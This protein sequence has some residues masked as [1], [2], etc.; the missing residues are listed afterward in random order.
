MISTS[1]N[2]P[3]TSNWN[4]SKDKSACSDSIDS[5]SSKHSLEVTVHCVPASETPGL[6]L[7][8]LDQHIHD[9]VKQDSLTHRTPTKL[10]GQSGCSPGHLSIEM[11]TIDSVKTSEREVTIDPK[12]RKES[13][14]L[15]QRYIKRKEAVDEKIKLIIELMKDESNHQLV[16]ESLKE[17][18]VIGGAEE[19]QFLLDFRIK[20]IEP[21]SILHALATI[22]FPIANFG[23]FFAFVIEEESNSIEVAFTIIGSLSTGVIE[24]DGVSALPGS[25]SEL[26]SVLTNLP[27][28]KKVFLGVFA[29]WLALATASD[30]LRVF[31]EANSKHDIPLSAFCAACEGLTILGVGGEAIHLLSKSEGVQREKCLPSC[32]PHCN[33]D[34]IISTGCRA[35][36]FLSGYSFPFRVEQWTNKLSDLCL[37]PEYA[38]TIQTEIIKGIIMIPHALILYL[39]ESTNNIIFWKTIKNS[40]LDIY[41]FTNYLEK[42]R[43]EKAD[44]LTDNE[45]RI[46]KKIYY[47]GRNFESI[48]DTSAGRKMFLWQLLGLSLTSLVVG[49]ALYTNYLYQIGLSDDTDTRAEELHAIANNIMLYNSTEYPGVDPQIVNSM[50]DWANIDAILNRVA[51][52]STETS[53]LVASFGL[54]KMLGMFLGTCYRPAVAVKNTVTSCFSSA[55]N[56]FQRHTPRSSPEQSTYS[57][58]PQPKTPDPT[59][60]DDR[61]LYEL[62]RYSE[63]QLDK[64]I[65][66]ID[67]TQAQSKKVLERNITV[68]AEED[69]PLKA[70][71]V[72]V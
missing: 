61:V 39:I 18:S 47:I 4:L 32:D 68:L 38:L 13:T 48:V 16:T 42:V 50:A 26:K 66:H 56:M 54:P 21:K 37:S 46:E 5:L 36:S 24:L 49:S 23:R 35:N 22:V 64:M 10:L 30:I 12:I 51:V 27:A 6:T 72:H 43:T 60:S 33:L 55:R 2:F 53:Y 70:V 31:L 1:G 3:K 62:R 45:L 69:A 71:I 8:K 9:P 59:M 19:Q 58:L 40:I 29:P 28:G 65:S 7:G 63:E 25:I 44:E 17:K 57:T 20:L 52:L 67:S 15:S 34:K 11:E 41:Y 14:S